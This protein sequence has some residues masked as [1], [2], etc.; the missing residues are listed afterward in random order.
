MGTATQTSNYRG[1][2]ESARSG[3]FRNG[4]FLL[5]GHPDAAIFVVTFKLQRQN[6]LK[7]KLAV[8]H[9]YSVAP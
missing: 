9:F 7:P 6:P 1:W 8:T 4:N 3:V 5:W 2:A